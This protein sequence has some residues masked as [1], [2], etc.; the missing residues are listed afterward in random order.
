MIARVATLERLVRSSTAVQALSPREACARIV[1]EAC[2]LLGADRASIFTAA[3]AVD[4]APRVLELSVAEGARSIVVPFGVGIA[5]TVAESGNVCNI[6]DAYTDPRFDP[7]ADKESGYKTQNI[8]C[9][10]IRGQNKDIVGVVQVINKAAGPFNEDDEEALRLLSTLAGVA[11]QNAFL[12][13]RAVL[14]QR[15]SEATVAL[16]QALYENMGVNSVI[17][18]LTNRL[19]AIARGGA[20]SRGL[21]AGVAAGGPDF[22]SSA[23]SR[24]RRGGSGRG[25]SAE[26]RRRRGGSGRESCVRPGPA[27]GPKVRRSWLRPSKA[28]RSLAH[29]GFAA[30]SRPLQVNCDRCTVFVIDRQAEEM[31]AMQGEVNIKFPLASPGLAP[32][33]GR[34]NQIIN[35][36]DA[37]E[38]PRFN[39]EIDKQTKYYTKTILCM[40]ITADKGKTVV[41]VAQMINKNRGHFSKDDERLLSVFLSIV[42]EI[43]KNLV[44]SKEKK[45]TKK[46]AG[47]DT[48]RAP[49]SGAMA[50]KPKAADMQ[51]A[52]EAFGE[53]G[54]G[55]DEDY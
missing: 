20:R 34:E 39:Q 15:R 28:R 40:P 33:C 6:H 47:R 37:Y 30:P 11:L 35:I 26:S 45:T 23:E 5:G 52:M 9:G 17:F 24:R 25:S 8:L 44:M 29:T 19:P 36:P 50:E 1:A 31:W 16:V 3:P 55:E 10:P 49:N 14:A 41:G 48:V 22:E 2:D 38:D 42:G 46:S 43:M 12:H 54:K 53:E 51:P 18:T 7:R 32:S 27:A 13:E 4:K 21:S